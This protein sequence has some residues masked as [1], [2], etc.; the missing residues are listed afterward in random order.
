LVALAN[1]VEECFVPEVRIAVCGFPESGKTTFLAAL[2]HLVTARVTRTMF[3]FYSLRDGDSTHLN[4]LAKRWRDAKATVRTDISSHKLIGMNL[5]DSTDQQVRLIF[6]DLSGESYRIMF[7]ERECMRDVSQILGAAHGMLLF[8][9]ADRIRQPLPIVTVAAQSKA[10]GSPH[11]SD[12]AVPWHPK[13]CPT[14][15][16][17]VDLLQL[18]R[19]PPLDVPFRR[20]AIILSAWDKVADEGQEPEDFLRERLPLLDQYLRSNSDEW[21]YRIFGVSAQGADYEKDNET[22]NSAQ[23][24]K[25]QRIR[26]LEPSERIVVRSNGAESCDLTEPIAWLAS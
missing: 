26:E 1:A 13:L 19:V 9:H 21:K 8:L 2:W 16:R 24:T 17:V 23:L 25:L 5:I 4:L 22:L 14:Q 15:V 18:L 7:E 10:L 6:P 12:Q 3:R 20:L 11:G